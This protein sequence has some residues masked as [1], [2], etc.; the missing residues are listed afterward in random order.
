MIKLALGTPPNEFFAA[1]DTGSSVTWVQ[2][3]PCDKCYPQNSEIFDPAQTAGSYQIVKCIS[4]QFPCPT[5]DGVTCVDNIC[6]SLV[7]YGD[8]SFS[9][10]VLSTDNMTIQS[11]ADQPIVV[12]HYIF[13][14]RT[15]NE[16]DF[17][18]EQAGIIG[19]GRGQRS[20][21]TQLDKYINGRFS[22]C[23]FP[24]IQGGEMQF[25]DDAVVQGQGV[26][27]TRCTQEKAKIMPST[28]RRWKHP[29]T[30]GDE[31]LNFNNNPGN[32]IIDSGATLTHF[33]RAFY[34]QIVASVTKQITAK[35]V[36]D[37]SKRLNVCF[38]ARSFKF[39]PMIGHFTG[40]DVVLNE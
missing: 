4:G 34:Q 24:D 3:Y 28:L 36:R 29:L 1:A 9:K 17:S 8:G 12:D 21:I 6:K 30:I 38:A 15:Y 10:G 11:T 14:C 22:Y 31:R 39:I 13:Q 19:L 20:L 7:A 26:V 37:P 18:P 16:G 5:F 33:P 35:P 27:T 23:L 32:I 2:C 40:A 25:G